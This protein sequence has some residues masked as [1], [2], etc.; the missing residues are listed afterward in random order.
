MRRIYFGTTA[1]QEKR[2]I[3]RADF[4]AETGQIGNAV[5]VSDS[6]RPGFIV[7][8]PN[9][10]NLY[11]TD[12]AGRFP[13]VSGAHV[14]A[15]E[16]NPDGT[17]SD[18]TTQPS[19]GKGPCHLSLSPDGRWLLAA[20]YRGGSCSVLPVLKNG[21]LGEP[22]SIQQHN[23]SGPNA[24]RQEQAHT[25]SFNI[26]P[27]GSF[28]I[29]A[30][31]GMDKM[32][33]YRIKDG[34]LSLHC[35][36]ETAP[37]A[38]PRHLV[39]HPNG[40]FAYVSMELNG[41]VGAYRY[42]VGTSSE[43]QTLPTLPTD[44]SGDNTVSEVQITPD[45]RFLFVGNRGHESLAIYAVDPET[46]TLTA[47]GHESTRGQHP[48]HFNIDPTGRFL[49]AA[50]MHSDTIVVFRIDPQTGQLEFTGSEIP[51]PAPSCVRFSIESNPKQA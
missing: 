48:R 42:G 15:Y 35:V 3:Y 39:F 46:G 11:A 43:I 47:R 51:V 18:L 13:G 1:T 26:T 41:T 36:T 19:G 31:L 7:I 16:I 50:N 25:H 49:I 40:R 27:D 24:K 12:A 5:R 8:H 10:K 9:G 45:G 2:G 6:V 34:A 4:D 17:L 30:D 33:M 28:A 23:G 44:F 14:S 32:M 29:A 20:N 21:A 22:A 37:G 38:G